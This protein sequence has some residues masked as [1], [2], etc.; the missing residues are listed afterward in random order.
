MVSLVFAHASAEKGFASFAIDFL[1]GGAS[2]AVSKTATAPIE[3]VKLL[4]QNQDEMIKAGRLSEPHKKISDCFAYTIKDKTLK[5]DGCGA[6]I[7]RTIGGAGVLAG[8]D[9]L[10]LIVFGKKYG[11]CGA[12]VQG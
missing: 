7:L 10:Q 12:Y 11:S 9:K 5:S 4:S 6:N 8:Y 1:M 2:V 3:H